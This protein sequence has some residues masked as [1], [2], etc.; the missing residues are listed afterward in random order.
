MIR[1][2]SARAILRAPLPDSSTAFAH[3]RLC[4]Q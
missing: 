3:D 4:P 2:H 1:C